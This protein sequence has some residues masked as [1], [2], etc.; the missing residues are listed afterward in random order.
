[1]GK[2]LLAACALLG[3]AQ[4]LCGQDADPAP[5]IDNVEITYLNGSPDRL[6][7]TGT[8]FGSSPGRVRFGW[9]S[10]M[11]ELAIHSWSND[12]VEVLANGPFE[13]KTHYVLLTTARQGQ[14]PSRSALADVA[15]DPAKKLVA[16]EEGRAAAGLANAPFLSE[17]QRIVINRVVQTAIPAGTSITFGQGNEGCPADK[18]IISFGCRFPVQL[19]GIQFYGGSF[20]NDE[21][22][23][24]GCGARLLRPFASGE[25]SYQITLVCASGR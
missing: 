21:L 12:H 3:S 8:G 20:N 2:Q 16:R 7:V 22:T 4:L 17:L 13:R 11:E 18:R 9:S 24:M 25:L 23:Q 15:V 5:S 10:L 6:K 14:R 1:M 19:D